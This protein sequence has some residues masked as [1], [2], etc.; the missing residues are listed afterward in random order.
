MPGPSPRREQ[1]R[2]LQVSSCS[3]DGGGRPRACGAL[4]LS[5]PGPA[6]F[7]TPVCTL[8]YVSPRCLSVGVRIG[9]VLC[10]GRPFAAGALAQPPVCHLPCILQPTEQPSEGGRI[11]TDT[12]V[13]LLRKLSP[14]KD[15][16]Y[17]VSHPSPAWDACQCEFVLWCWGHAPGRESRAGDTGARQQGIGG[18]CSIL[19]PGQWWQQ[20]QLCDSGPDCPTGVS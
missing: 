9:G 20:C 4:S 3:G 7:R 17:L 14:G 5:P 11:C 8:R 6:L 2:G 13:S 10:T 15:G 1:D 16:G 19:F 18:G 12:A